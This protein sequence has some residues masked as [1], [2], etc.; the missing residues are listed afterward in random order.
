MSDYLAPD[1][2][3]DALR[4]LGGLLLGVGFL[5]WYLRK[6]GALQGELVLFLIVAA[7]GAFLYCLGT[8]TEGETGGL[9]SWQTVYSVFGLIFVPLALSRFVDM[10]GSPGDSGQ[11]LNVFWIF[12][13]T[14]ALAL[15]AGIAAGVRVQLL[16]ASIALIVS[17]SALWDKILSGGISDHYGVYR[18]LL[19]ILAIGLLTGAVYLWREDPGPE[20]GAA[21]A[22]GLTGEPGLWKASELLTG[23]GIAAVLACS[24]GLGSAISLSFGAAGIPIDLNVPGT[25]LLWDILLLLV[26]LGLVGVGS[27]I[28]LRGPVYVGSI[29]LLLFLFIAGSDLD[30]GTSAR[31][32][33]FGLW[34]LVLMVLGALG[35]LLSGVREASQGDR[36]REL[37]EK[38]RGR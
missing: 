18:G 15:Y 16:L 25:S 9:R 33:D 12:A 27:L 20:R 34:P 17:W 4:K 8:F 37:I 21:T 11:A 22:T 7:P 36:P 13:V 6:Q 28:G 38:L 26:S 1:D 24:L 3:R 10:V 31:P 23:A 5:M 32:N 35:V 30:E 19:G 2:T 29:G 14:A